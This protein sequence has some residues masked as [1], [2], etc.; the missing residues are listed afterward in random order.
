MLYP[1]NRYTFHSSKN[2]P[3]YLGSSLRVAISAT[4]ANLLFLTTLSFNSFAF[5]RLRDPHQS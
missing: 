5:N 2:R 4:R 3:E 1:R